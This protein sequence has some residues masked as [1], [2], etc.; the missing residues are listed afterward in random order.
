MKPWK[1]S[2]L[3]TYWSVSWWRYDA[4][5]SRGLI[6]IRADKKEMWWH[7]IQQNRHLLET[8]QNSFFLLWY[9]KNALATE[10][11]ITLVKNM[12]LNFFTDYRHQ[13][14]VKYSYIWDFNKTQ[15][16]LIQLKK[17]CKIGKQNIT[18]PMIHEKTIGNAPVSQWFLKHY[19]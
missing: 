4:S 19:S 14:Q 2:A 15:R 16:T 12:N 9:I 7:F 8:C 11:S 17:K 5:H 18:F 3:Q 1:L 10:N 13:R 6:W